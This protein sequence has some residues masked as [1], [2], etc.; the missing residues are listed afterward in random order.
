MR[1]LTK[2]LLGITAAIF[3]NF[4]VANI[5]FTNIAHGALITHLE[6]ATN[7]GGFFG[8]VTFENNGVNTVT[9]TADISA[10]LDL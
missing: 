2:Q 9:I 3:A 4:I 7:G 6:D 10:P 8:A 5:V 1:N